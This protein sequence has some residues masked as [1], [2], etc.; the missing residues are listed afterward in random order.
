[1]L[2]SEEIKLVALFIIKLCLSEL[3]S[4]SVSQSV[5][6]NSVKLEILK[7]SYQLGGR[8]YG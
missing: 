1:M 3:I 2:H 7:I 4:Q 5:N 6:R 8:V